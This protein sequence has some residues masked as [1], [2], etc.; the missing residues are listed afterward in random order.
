MKMSKFETKN[1]LFWCFWETIF[2]KL[3]PYI[4][5]VNLQNFTKKQ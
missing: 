2:K 3:F 1:G 4:K 5:F